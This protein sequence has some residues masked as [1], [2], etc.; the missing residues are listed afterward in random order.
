M[1]LKI[2]IPAGSVSIIWELKN[3]RSQPLPG[4]L[5]PPP[6]EIPSSFHTP[7]SPLTQMIV[8]MVS[9]CGLSLDLLLQAELGQHLPIVPVG[10]CPGRE[11]GEV[12]RHTL[13]LLS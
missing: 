2:G 13:Q 4:P 7:K 3:A 10:S 12:I 11:A 8:S 9:S 1:G 6:L 5:S